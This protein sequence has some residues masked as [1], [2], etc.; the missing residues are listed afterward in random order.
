MVLGLERWFFCCEL[1]QICERLL[2]FGTVIA[3]F[4]RFFLGWGLGVSLLLLTWAAFFGGRVYM[5]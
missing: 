2:V 4:L 3:L 5:H 1:F